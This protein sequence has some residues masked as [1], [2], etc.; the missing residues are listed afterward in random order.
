M[1]VVL[2]F[3]VW[4]SAA[5]ITPAL[6]QDD[7]EIDLLEDDEDL[8]EPDL[9]SGPPIGDEP[10]PD[11]DDEP[12]L[13]EPTGPT[14]TGVDNASIYRDWQAKVADL[15]ADEEVQEW[16][17]YLEKYPDS[18]FRSRIEERIE[19]LMDELYGERIGDDD[20]AEPTDADLGELR[21]VQPLLLENINP[22]T[23][24]TVGFEYGLPTWLNLY[25]GYEHA[26]FRTFSIAGGV[27]HR[28]TGWSVEAGVKWAPIK[29]LRTGTVVA[30]LGDLRFNAIPAFPAFRPQ[31]GIGQVLFD[32]RLHLQAQFGM[33]LEIRAQSGVHLIG[34]ANATFLVSPTVALFLEG[35][36]DVKNLT[37]K[38]GGVFTF[39]T[40]T[41]GIKFFPKVGKREPQAL[42]ANIGATMPFATNYWAYHYGSIMGQATYYLPER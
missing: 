33:D 40:A 32:N 1:R 16:E 21:L 34:G 22:R 20:E 15:E 38:D 7:D 29:S 41:F 10:A 14:G 4:A 17:R 5:S 8:P 28:Y 23:K 3:L 30:L 13:D 27:R 42:E 37:W 24:V 31:V 36:T 6:A 11:L 35:G 18:S 19:T 2:G 9:P 12:M 39:T 25:A 26:L